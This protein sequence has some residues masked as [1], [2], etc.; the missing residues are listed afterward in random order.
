M[1]LKQLQSDPAAFRSTLLI[2]TD[3]GAQRFSD[4]MDE[5]QDRDFRALDSGWQRAVIGTKVQSTY[6]RGWLERPRGHSKS[7][8]LGIMAAWALFASRRSLSGI[9]AAGDQDQARLL[10]DAIGRLLYV[11]PWLAELLEV[12]AYRVVNTR[13]GS[14][15]E[16]ISSDAPTSYGLTPD[17]IVADELVH[18]KSRDLWDSLLSSAA[19]RSTCQLVCISNAGMSDDWTWQLRQAV[20]KDPGWYFS[21][22]EGPV[23]SWI[24]P[25]LLAEQERLLPAIAYRRLWLNEWTAG[26]GDALDPA[27]LAQ[28]FLPDL[29]PMIR[30]L[31]GYEFVAGLDVGIVRDAS[32]V[33]IL[34]VRRGRRGHGRIRLAHTKVWRP[35][36]GKKV[37]LTDVEDE[38]SQLH[39]RFHLKQTMYDPWQAVHLAQRLQAG[40]LG[41]IS[42]GRQRRE[43]LPL[44]E[45]PFTPKH[46]QGM[47]TACLEAFH[48]RRVELFP[49]PDLQHDL[50][51]MRVEERKDGSFRLVFP[52]DSLGHGDLGT[53][54]L[55]ALLGATELAGKKRI[56]L[57]SLTVDS[58]HDDDQP[59][60]CLERELTR[61]R[62]RQASY[63]AEMNRPMEEDRHE[64]L[65]GFAR[66]L[67]DRGLL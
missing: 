29:R 50:S 7:L 1:D 11:N 42:H 56:R 37:N 32:A 66:A 5:W 59:M 43:K 18:W 63:E 9:G 14:C 17:F 3:A 27:C 33:C 54:F 4:V 25:E 60:T 19:K 67:Q 22:L 39:E 62:A 51:R 21:R 41:R 45:V 46:L 13:T 24:S 16:I 38:L 10:R 28:A 65:A 48:D 26:G 6:S 58:N 8:D 12:Q 61:V 15:L 49:D 23:A 36:K 31:A 52:R 47:A 53:A 40:G 55:L 44:V 30:P 20:R 35:A 2:D 64:R 34:G 57:G